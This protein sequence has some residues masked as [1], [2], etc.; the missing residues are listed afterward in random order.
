MDFAIS[1]LTISCNTKKYQVLEG[2][3]QGTTFRVI[4]ESSENF[5]VKIYELLEQFDKS[6]STYQD[7]SIISL[8]NKN[9]PDIAVDDI[10]RTFFEKSKYASE[11]T[12]GYFDITVGPLV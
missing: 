9:D 4:Y 5:N 10:F 11:K 12:D 6:L 7:S 3:T 2:Y 1:V 8:I